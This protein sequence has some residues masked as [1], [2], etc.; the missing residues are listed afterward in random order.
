[1]EMVI[2][3]VLILVVIF[4]LMLGAYASKA[5]RNK[6]ILKGVVDSMYLEEREQAEHLLLAYKLDLSLIHI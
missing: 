4:V 5:E 3:V 2:I 1:M 6:G